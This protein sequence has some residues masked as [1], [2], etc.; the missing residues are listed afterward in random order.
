MPHAISR[1]LWDD[2]FLYIAYEVN[3]RFLKSTYRNQ[4][5][6][7]WEQDAV[8]LMF[9][10]GGDGKNY[11][12]LQVS[13]TGNTFDTQYDSRRQPR[14]FGHTSWS[15]EVKVG[16]STQGHVNDGSSDRGYTVEMAIP[17]SAFDLAHGMLATMPFRANMFILDAKKEGGQQACG[18]SAPLLPDFHIPERFGHIT[19]KPRAHTP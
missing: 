3:D 2:Q 8:E 16:V 7:L 9:D 4:D 13:P 6:H 14:P 12:E 1:W 10:P 5:D 17:W 15:S 18:W 19:F 11:Y